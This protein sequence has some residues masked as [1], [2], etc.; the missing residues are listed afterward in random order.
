[1]QIV[2][3][4]LVRNSSAKTVEKIKH[5]RLFQFEAVPSFF[6][7]RYLPAL[8]TIDP[9]EDGSRSAKKR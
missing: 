5:L 2:W 3:P 7:R 1:M 6:K 4:G 9:E 8:P